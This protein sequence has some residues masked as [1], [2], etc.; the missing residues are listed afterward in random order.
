MQ[1]V[2]SRTWSKTLIDI[3]LCGIMQR[4]LLIFPLYYVAEYFHVIF[5]SKLDNICMVW[6]D[7]GSSRHFIPDPRR[8]HYCNLRIIAGTIHDTATRAPID[9]VSHIY[10]EIALPTI[11]TVKYNKVYFTQ[12]Q[13]EEAECA[14]NLKNTT[15]LTTRITLWM[16]DQECQITILVLGN[17][18]RIKLLFLAKVYLI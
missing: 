9:T 5:E 13:M 16:V 2:Q 14:R 7:A 11:Y 3:D 6:K 17:L 4:V 10:H 18:L 8:L 1:N 15:R 12:R